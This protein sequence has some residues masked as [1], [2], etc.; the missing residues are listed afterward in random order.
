M[1]SK[2]SKEEIEVWL[3]EKYVE[4][5]QQET[6]N[7]HIN[8]KLWKQRYIYIDLHEI[9]FVEFPCLLYEWL[10]RKT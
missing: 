1:T 4:F 2:P 5:V 3:T 8:L 6:K 9:F 10:K 7:P